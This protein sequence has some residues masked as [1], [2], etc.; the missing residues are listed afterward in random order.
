M[1]F[2]DKFLTKS[3]EI[4]GIVFTPVWSFFCFNLYMVILSFCHLCWVQIVL[5]VSE[6]FPQYLGEILEKPMKDA[7]F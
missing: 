3:Y 2:Y 6:I 1:I 7:W 5:L 4:F